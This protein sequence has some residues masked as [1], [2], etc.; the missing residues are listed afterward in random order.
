VSRLSMQTQQQG[1]SDGFW[2]CYLLA[3]FVLL[4]V[5]LVAD[6]RLIVATLLF[7]AASFTLACKLRA[8]H[9]ALAARHRVNMLEAPEYLL[10]DAMHCLCKD[11]LLRA[12]FYSC[13]LLVCLI[14]CACLLLILLS[15]YAVSCSLH[16]GPGQAS[17][18]CG[19]KWKMA[20]SSSS[21]NRNN[22]T[23]SGQQPCN[24]AAAGH[25]CSAT[26][27]HRCSC[28]LLQQQQQQQQRQ[29]RP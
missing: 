18:G 5:L 12:C 4:S 6:C 28:S 22:S 2:Q 10:H 17:S 25:A 3:H 11:V 13:S 8:C 21:S 23:S 15:C 19:A 29:C 27:L 9:A 1:S 26:V 24:G 14:S 7:M 16:L 20:R